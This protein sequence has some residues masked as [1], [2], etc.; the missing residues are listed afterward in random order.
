MKNI[1]NKLNKILDVVWT[2]LNSRVFY[3]IIIALLVVFGLRKCGNEKDLK[4]ENKILEQNVSAANDSIRL[5]KTKTGELQAQKQLY[6]KTEK[7]LK[8][9]NSELY[10]RIKEQDGRIISLSRTVIKLKQDT[11]ILHDSIRYL[12]SVIGEAVQIDSNTWMLPWELEYKWDETNYDIFKGKTFVSVDNQNPLKLKHD[13]TL[14]YFRE[15]QIDITFG[16][17]VVDGKYNVF[18]QSAYPGFT[19]ESME[20]VYIDPNTNKDIKGLIKKN[21]WFTGFSF[22]VSATIGYDVVR[23]QPAIVVGPSLNYN[24]YSW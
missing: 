14:L 22:A 23:Q 19:P 18:I 5:Y 2:L 1:K 15:S 20:G 8:K 10:K 6:I 9:E 12:N 13:N 11:S 3:F 4:I 7:E 21:H 24:I 17:K 16:E